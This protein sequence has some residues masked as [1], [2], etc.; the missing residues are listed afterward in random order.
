M[1]LVMSSA[2][3][4]GHCWVSLLERGCVLGSEAESL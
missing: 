1:F 4:C 3:V 2:V